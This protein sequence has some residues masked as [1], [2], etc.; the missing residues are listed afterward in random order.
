MSSFKQINP[1]DKITD[2]PTSPRSIVAMNRCGITPPDILYVSR[3]ELKH[4][5]AYKNLTDK[6]FVI[7]YDN[8]EAMRKE[9]LS[10]AIAEYQLILEQGISKAE[11]AL[12]PHLRFQTLLQLHLHREGAF[13]DIHA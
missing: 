1:A 11:A 13:A 8:Y 4:R 9:A 5:I 3:E 7:Y 6:E 10:Q 2:P 12:Y